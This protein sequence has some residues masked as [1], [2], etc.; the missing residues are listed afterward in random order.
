MGL[1]TELHLVS[2]PT[3]Q[4]LCNSLH[5]VAATHSQINIEFTLP[6]LP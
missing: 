1:E 2:Q 3:D 5:R 4:F 6:E